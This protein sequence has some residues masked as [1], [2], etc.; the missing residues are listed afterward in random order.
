[1][2]INVVT[3]F[4][5]VFQSFL[6]SS[7]LKRAIDNKLIE[8]NFYNFREFS[9]A[10]NKGV[11]D[12]NYGGGPGMVLQVEPIKDCLDSINKEGPVIALTPTG[13]VFDDKCASLLAREKDITLLCGHYEG[14]DERVYK[15]VDMEVSIG[16][17]ILTG[18]ETA[19]LVLIDAISRKVDGVIKSESVENDSFAQ[20]I[21]DYPVY[22]K[23]YEFDGQ[24]VP[25]V[26]LSGNHQEI[27]KFRY[28]KAL[29]KTYLRRKDLIEKNIDK[30]DQEVLRKIKE[31]NKE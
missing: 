2:R 5:E 19:A 26:L 15:Y 10:K 27:E 21:F 12:T 24:K 11:D 18:G 8:I 29:E 6:N 25:D 16:D 13:K 20:A 14:F 22:T 28:E 3:L 9:K 31:M 17:F 23:P 7:I 1:M 4:P 30:I